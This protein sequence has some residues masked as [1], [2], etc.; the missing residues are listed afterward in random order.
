MASHAATTRSR[1]STNR[2]TGAKPKVSVLGRVAG[3]EGRR[4]LRAAASDDHGDPAVLNRLG[5]RRGV[6]RLVV[7]PRVGEAL[8][9][10]RCPQP[11]DQRQLLLE[12]VEALAEG[13]KRDS[14]G[15]GARP[16]TTRLRVPAR[17]A[18]R[19][20]G[21]PRRRRSRAGPGWRNVADVTS[22]PRRIVD[23]VGDAG[24]RHPRVGRTWEP[25]ALERGA[26][27]Q[28]V[29]AAE[30]RVKAELLGG[31][32]QREQI[33]VRRALLGFGEHAE[34][35]EFEHDARRYGSSARW[36]GRAPARRR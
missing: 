4:A 1:C 24:Q 28:V 36:R 8:A 12:A 21:R 34:L 33:V 29:V 18:L 13:R 16:R 20:S 11:G 31:L 9:D 5:Q 10:R 25:A 7:R 17:P 23:V 35:R 2:S 3:G 22:V 32:R 30:E 26:H 15:T 6:D 19:T 14:V 27:R